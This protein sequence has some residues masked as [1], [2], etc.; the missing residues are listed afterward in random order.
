MLR[1]WK[2]FLRINSMR[3]TNILYLLTVILLNYLL[4]AGEKGNDHQFILKDLIVQ[5]I[6]LV[7]TKGKK[8]KKY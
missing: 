5:G 2:Y 7:G 4:R 3:V 1:H 6:R 8:I